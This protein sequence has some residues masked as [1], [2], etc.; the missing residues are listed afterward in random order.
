[1]SPPAADRE[2]A[3]MQLF[4]DVQLPVDSCKLQ[5]GDLVDPLEA[6]QAHLADTGCRDLPSGPPRRGLDPVDQGI[7]RLWPDRSLV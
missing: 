7:D 1:M 5:I 3:Q 6:G 2:P 4:L